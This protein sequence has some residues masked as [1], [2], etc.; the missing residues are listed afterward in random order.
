MS[1]IAHFLLQIWDIGGQTIGGPM[2]DKYIFGAQGALVVYDVTNGASF[3]NLEDWINLIK[4]FTKDQEKVII[5]S[6]HMK[7]AV[8]MLQSVKF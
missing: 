7:N 2:L 3:E 8:I 5:Y 4:K 1:L 6:F